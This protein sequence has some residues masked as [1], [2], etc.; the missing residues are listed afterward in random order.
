[1]T[2]AKVMTS[3]GWQ[4]LQMVGPAG[5]QGPQGP[6]GPSMVALVGTGR[7]LGAGF[8]LSQG[9]SW[10]DGP[11]ARQLVYTTP[12]YLTRALI[13]YQSRWDARTA[14]W[15]W[16]GPGIKV[17]PSPITDYGG[18]MDPYGLAEGSRE[19]VAGYNGGVTWTTPGGSFWVDLAANTTYSF[20][21]CN[22][23]GSGD[24]FWDNSMKLASITAA[25][26]TR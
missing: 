17:S 26:Y 23:A 5:P 20:S 8:L 24:W 11:S 19:I 21:H 3:E 16:C 6:I 15:G 4:D 12:N 1:M 18:F 2:V 22:Y 9:Q 7:Q 14:A 25:V 10:F 13:T